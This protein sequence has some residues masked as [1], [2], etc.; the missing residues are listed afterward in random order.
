VDGSYLREITRINKSDLLIIDDFGIY[1]TL[2]HSWQN[3]YDRNN[4]GQTW[5]EFNHYYFPGT[6]IRVV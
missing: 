3:A 1:T 6:G 5:K 4:G 2:R